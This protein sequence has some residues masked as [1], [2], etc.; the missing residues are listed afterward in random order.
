MIPFFQKLRYWMRRSS[1]EDELREELQFHLD[2]DAEQRRAE[3]LADNEA[4]WAARRELGNLGLVQE[5]A[6]AAWTWSLLDKLLRDA[7]YASRSLAHNPAFTAIAVLTL[8]LGIG[9]NTAIFSVVNAVVLRALPY[10]QPGQLYAIR[11]VLRDGAKR[12]PLTCVNAGNFLLWTPHRASFSGMA[13][14]EP[15]TGNLNLKDRTVQIHGVRA[16]ANL[17]KILG[18]EL[19]LGRP[20]SPGEDQSG[21]SS[22]IILSHSL[23]LERFH[24]DPSIVGTTLRVNGFPLLVAG[25]LPESFYFPKQNELYPSTI[26][27]WTHSIQ[28]FVNLGLQKNEI[29]PGFQMENFAVIARL[30][31]GVS[32]QEAEDQLDVGETQAAKELPSGVQ[33]YVTLIPLKASVI[34]STDRSLWMLMSGAALVLL[35][36]C[37]NLAGLLIAK[38]VAR[39]HEVAVRT[40]LGASRGDILRQFLIEGLLLA[41]AGGVLGVTAAYLG[42]R[43]LVDAAP[44]EIPRL[45]TVAIDERVLLFSSAMTV[46]AVVLFS[47]LPAWRLMHEASAQAMRASGPNLTSGRSISR[48]HQALA[49][50]EIALCTVL[51]CSAL[52]IAQ[53][54]ARVMAANAWANVSHVI[55]LSFSVPPDHYQEDSKRAQLITKLLDAVRQNPGVQAAGITL[56]TPLTGQEWSNDVNFK[57]IPQSPRDAINANWRFISPGYF[58]ALGLPLVSGRYLSPSDFGKHY[59]LISNQLAKQL[60][61]GMNAVG[62]HVSNLP[63]GR[64]ELYQVIGVVTD[65][66]AKADQEAPPM[67]YVPYWQWPPFEASLVVR[68]TEDPRAIAHRIQDLIQQTDDEIAT[69]QAETLRDILNN[70]TAPRRFVMFLGLFFAASATFLAALGLYGLIA[71]SVSQRTREIGVRMAIGANAG[72]IFRMMIAQAAKLAV[73]GLALG[74]GGAWAVTRLLTSFLYEISPGDPLTFSFVCAVLLAVAVAAGFVPACR[75][76]SIDPVTALKWE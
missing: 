76:A 6:R 73:I 66:R 52:L 55:T 75:A 2:E 3:G 22:S 35:L 9:S 47:L 46:A 50:S 8:A 26:A 4:K 17:F 53:S 11:E 14:V 36:V 68:T 15:A 49:A 19:Q 37:V 13:L 18:V 20:F 30:R 29:Q 23:W 69:T 63:N 24:S 43:L 41:T 64:A 72:Q 31:P 60:P 65:A 16:S 62:L 57:E 42:L 67:V 59:L 33:A 34:G 54:L 10:K 44:V 48:I 39:T 7:R 56:A 25:V 61:H 45:Q 27:G 5:D 70:A 28:Y 21:R 71:L 51:L 32:H 38:G 12:F 58:Q 74:V 40:A 1:K